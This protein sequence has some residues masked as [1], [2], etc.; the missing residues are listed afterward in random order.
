MVFMGVGAGYY[1]YNYN[2]WMAAKTEHTCARH[3]LVG[4]L[5]RA[6]AWSWA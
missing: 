5:R 6:S 4:R 1:M 3:A 2:D